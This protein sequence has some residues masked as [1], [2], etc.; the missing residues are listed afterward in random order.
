MSKKNY[1]VARIVTHTKASIGKC[2]RHNERKNE[3]YGNMNVDL[4]RSSLNVQFRNCGGRT[5]NEILNQLIAEGAISLRGLKENAK[6]YDEMILDVNSDYFEKH[7]GC[8][9]AK[10]FYEKA[11]H[12]AAKVYGEEHILSAVMHA[13]EINLALTTKYG[14]PVYHYHIHIIALPVVE[15]QV[16]WTKRCK[17]L[18]WLER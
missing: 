8:D 13:D 18:S 9:F 6:I 11:F 16:L 12:F 2:E 7:G 15:K 10:Q 17:I 4:S 3:T 1:T 14:H 5:Y